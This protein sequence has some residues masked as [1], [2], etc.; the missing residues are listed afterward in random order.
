MVMANNLD[1]GAAFN[2]GPFQGRGLVEKAVKF[3]FALGEEWCHA[4]N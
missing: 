1:D 4:E 2:M 3:G